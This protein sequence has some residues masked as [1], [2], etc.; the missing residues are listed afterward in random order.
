MQHVLIT[1][2]ASKEKGKVKRKPAAEEERGNAK[3]TKEKGD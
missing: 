2:L 3:R 1:G